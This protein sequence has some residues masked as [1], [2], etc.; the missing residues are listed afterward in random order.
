MKIRFVLG[1]LEEAVGNFGVGYGRLSFRHILL[2][3][4]REEPTFWPIERREENY[5]WY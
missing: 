3:G 1:Q 2:N 4:N 5:G